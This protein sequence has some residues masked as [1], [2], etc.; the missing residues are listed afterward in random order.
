[1]TFPSLLDMKYLPQH[2][3]WV[4][5]GFLFD[6]VKRPKGEPHGRKLFPARVRGLICA[7]LQI[8]IRFYTVHVLTY[9]AVNDE[10]LV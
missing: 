7:S 4:P 1:M 8:I 9:Q 6:D 2:F 5:D 3:A 10:T